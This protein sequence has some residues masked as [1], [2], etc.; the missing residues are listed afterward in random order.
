M[1]LRNG[2]FLL[3]FVRTYLIGDI[4]IAKLLKKPTSWLTSQ[5]TN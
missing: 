1:H 2:F 5:L 4:S 3:D